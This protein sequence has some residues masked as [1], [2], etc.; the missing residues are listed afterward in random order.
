MMVK[1]GWKPGDGFFIIRFV[2]SDNTL[3]SFKGI[4]KIKGSAE[5]YYVPIKTDVKGFIFTISWIL[6]RISLIHILRNRCCKSS[7]CIFNE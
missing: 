2:S 7:R 1:M 4:G 6:F 5:H 3:S